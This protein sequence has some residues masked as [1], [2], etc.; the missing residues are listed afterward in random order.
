MLTMMMVRLTMLTML[1][2]EQLKV[3]EGTRASID[4]GHDI[5]ASRTAKIAYDPK[6]KVK[7]AKNDC[8]TSYNEITNE[9]KATATFER[10]VTCPGVGG[11]P[12]RRKNDYNEYNNAFSP[13]D[14]SRGEILWWSTVVIY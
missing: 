3:T 7:R 2:T 13:K 1:S 14:P 10:E 11:N 9:F 6:A 12:C 5:F 8:F 4:E